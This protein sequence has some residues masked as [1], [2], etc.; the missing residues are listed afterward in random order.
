[1]TLQWFIRLSQS[2]KMLKQYE[3]FERHLNTYTKSQMKSSYFVTAI[4][5]YLVDKGEMQ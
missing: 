2:M 4:A 1:M 5:S 3:G